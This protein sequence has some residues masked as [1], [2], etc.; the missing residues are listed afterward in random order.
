MS[1]L[2]KQSQHQSHFHSDQEIKYATTKWSQLVFQ[3]Q[4]KGGVSL[5]M[6]DDVK[7]KHK[8]L[9]QQQEHPGHDNL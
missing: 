9:E 6:K 7:K 3:K 4:N 8:V 2:S 1:F 5:Q